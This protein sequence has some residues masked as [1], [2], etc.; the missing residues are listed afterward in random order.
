[1]SAS[2]LARRVIASS[3]LPAPRFRY[4]P[5]VAAGSFAF[6]SGM[7]GLDPES[8]KLVNGGAHAE[9]ARIL[10]NLRGLLDEQGWSLDQIVVARIYCSD[11]SAFPEV[12]AAWEAV[13]GEGVPPARTSVGVAAL[14]LGAVVE[15]EFQ[16]VVVTGEDSHG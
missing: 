1:M 9:A 8:G 14:P 3:V 16:L 11:F 4:S 5:V 7:V 12:N 6:V 2:S 10:A 13:F 15:M